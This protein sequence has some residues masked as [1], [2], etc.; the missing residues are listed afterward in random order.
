MTAASGTINLILAALGGE[1][2]GVLTNWVIDVAEREGWLCQSTSLAGVAQRTGATIYYLELFPREAL[3]GNALPVMSL[4]PAQGDID[5]AIASEI[6]EAGRMVQRGFV[7]PER[8]TLIASDHRVYGI[9]EKEHLADGIV[10]ASVLQTVAGQYARDYIH[11]D[12][13]TLANEHGTVI[14]AVLLGALAGAGVLPFATDSYRAV[15]SAT[16]KAVASNLAAFEASYQR[17]RSRGV[18]QF[19]PPAGAAGPDRFQLPAATTAQGEKLLQRLRAFPAGCHEILYLGLQKLVDYQDYAYAH[20]Y[21]DELESLLALDS[22]ADDYSLVRECGRYLVLW[23][24][25]EDIP[26]VA[27]LKT[28]PTRMAKIRTEVQAEPEQLFSVTEFFRPRV[29]E[30]C[31][32]LPKPLGRRLLAS[33]GSRRVLGWFTGGKRLR[34]NTITVFVLLRGLAGMRR[35]R[36]ASLGYSHEH[37]LIQGWLQAVRR[38]AGSD[39]ALALELVECGRLV[40]GY[41]DTRART[42]AQMQEILAYAAGGGVSA[43]AVASLRD[44]ALADDEGRAFSLALA[45]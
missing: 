19:Q 13:L 20:Q 7:T 41:G 4:F 23:M 9:T 8:T 16:G 22:G 31:A 21:L 24:C 38:A 35:W 37:A 5:I 1:G 14:S 43:A 6:A 28:R 3:E 11:Y 32:L 34:T 30:M 27:Q 2:G 17:A 42:T 36:R 33:A 25:Y 45:A 39:H 18:E 44:A 29:E 26:R 12:M 40:K 15:I 10:D